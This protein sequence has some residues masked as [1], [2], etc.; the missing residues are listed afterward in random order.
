MWKTREMKY[1]NSAIYGCSSNFIRSSYLAEHLCIYYDYD[2]VTAR[3]CAINDIRGDRRQTPGYYGDVSADD[4]IFDL[5]AETDGMQYDQSFVDHVS[6]FDLNGFDNDPD[7]V[8]SVIDDGAEHVRSD[9]EVGVGDDN[10][11]DVVITILIMW[12]VILILWLVIL[13]MLPMT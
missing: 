12:L 9:N 5:L 1:W 8:Y 6:D 4:S 7:V 10:D 3:E 2:R 11:F 13:M